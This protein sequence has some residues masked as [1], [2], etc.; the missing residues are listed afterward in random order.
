MFRRGEK[1]P[2]GSGVIIGCAPRSP[3][4]KF[5][6]LPGRFF[7][8][9]WIVEATTEFLFLRC[10]F[11]PPNNKRVSECLK[12]NSHEEEKKIA[13]DKFEAFGGS[14]SLF[15][16]HGAEKTVVGSIGEK[17]RGPVF[18]QRFLWP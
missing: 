16:M 5:W 11:P 14:G 4:P 15:A 18:C 6:S 17:G 2:N 7:L 10:D 1:K 13:A 12:K 3:E 8:P 9:F